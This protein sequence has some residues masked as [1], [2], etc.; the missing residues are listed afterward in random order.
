[1]SQKQN[2]L[3]P[4]N[5]T[6]EE[7][8]LSLAASFGDNILPEDIK[9]LLDPYHIQEHF[10][11][12][13]AW[14]FH[15]DFWDDSLPESAKRDLVANAWEWHR[16]KGTRYAIRRSLETL[17]FSNV[18]ITEWFDAGTIP[19]TFKISLYPMNETLARTAQRCIHEYKPARSRLLEMISR[20]HIDPEELDPHERALMNQNFILFDDYPWPEMVYNGKYAYDNPEN[21]FAPHYGIYGRAEAL[22]PTIC[23]IFS[24]T[25]WAQIR[26][27]DEDLNYDG[28]NTYGTEAVMN[29]EL[30]EV[31]ITVM[32]E[33]AEPAERCSHTIQWIL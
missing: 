1:M 12:F 16:K 5:S 7:R 14:A 10:L 33:I 31:P 3:L 24:E 25:V 26:Y 9:L 32:R 22:L 4:S 8:A 21:E 20:F 19:H 23:N 11:P 6:K 15:V 30:H 28:T 18:D 27:G 2:S 29:E 13:L 17:G